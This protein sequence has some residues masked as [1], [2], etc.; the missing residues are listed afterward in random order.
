MNTL[1][2]KKLEEFFRKY[3]NKVYKKGQILIHSG[4]TPDG[5]FYIKRGIV[6]EYAISKQGEEIVINLF[7]DCSFFPMSWGVNQTENIYFYEAMTEVDVWRA[8]REDVVLFIK[9]QPE[10]LFDLLS[11]VFR[12]IDGLLLRMTYLMSSDAYSRLIIELLL[13]ARRFSGGKSHITLSISEKDLAAQAGMT[14]ETVSREMKV[15]KQKSLVTYKNGDFI[16][17][18]IKNLEAELHL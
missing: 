4:D 18:S 15:L 10:V 16:I 1:I 14:R 7:K 13:Y 9:E 11:R 2:Q 8:P 12:G 6:K 5:I 3:T 17:P